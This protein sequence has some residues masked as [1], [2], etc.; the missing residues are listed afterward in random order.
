[1]TSKSVRWDPVPRQPLHNLTRMGGTAES[2]ATARIQA[3]ETGI[4]RQE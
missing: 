3:S 4:Q 1:M 2:K